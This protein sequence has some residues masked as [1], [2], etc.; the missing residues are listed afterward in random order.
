MAQKMVVRAR[1]SFPATYFIL[2]VYEYFFY[3][4]LRI[5]VQIF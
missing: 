1:K 2:V 3:I 4:R 5:S